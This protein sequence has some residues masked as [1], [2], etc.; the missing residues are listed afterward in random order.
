MEAQCHTARL[1]N[2]AHGGASA[3][4]GRGVLSSRPVIDFGGPGA[5]QL[6]RPQPQESNA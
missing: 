2:V 6:C 5:A 3:S 4:P 1:T